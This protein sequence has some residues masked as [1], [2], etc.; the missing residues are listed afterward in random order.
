MYVTLPPGSILQVGS[1]RPQITQQDG[2]AAISLSGPED[3]YI[4]KPET[5][6][7]TEATPLVLSQNFNLNGS[8]QPRGPSL[9][10]RIQELVF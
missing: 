10:I 5:L 8:E 1:G 4:W 6:A 2:D 7:V 9:H 3:G